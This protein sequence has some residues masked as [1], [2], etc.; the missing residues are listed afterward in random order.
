MDYNALP[1]IPDEPAQAYA[2]F[3]SNESG[4]ELLKAA[5]MD[6]D[7]GAVSHYFEKLTAAGFARGAVDVLAWR[8]SDD[9]RKDV[10]KS[11][12][13]DSP[14]FG[15][16]VLKIA[17]KN[18]QLLAEY[19]NVS[20][21]FALNRMTEEK[22]FGVIA[23]LANDGVVA[24][25]ASL[26]LLVEA[27]KFA[28]VEK[29]AAK[30]PTDVAEALAAPPAVRSA[31]TAEAMEYVIKAR[32]AEFPLT[33]LDVLNCIANG[34]IEGARMLVQDY[35][36]ELP[37]N[38]L[39]ND[40]NKYLTSQTFEGANTL[41]NRVFLKDEV[42]PN[43]AGWLTTGLAGVQDAPMLNTWLD[44]AKPGFQ[45][46]P[47]SGDR[48]G[49][50]NHLRALASK[51]NG[52]E[53]LTVLRDRLGL[54]HGSVEA[55]FGS[56]KT[57]NGGWESAFTP[58]KADL[59]QIA[60]FGAQDA[61]PGYGLN[62]WAAAL[63]QTASD[64]AIEAFAA[65]GIE[66]DRKGFNLAKA[67][68]ASRSRHP[69]QETTDTHH[70]TE[71][72]AALKCYEKFSDRTND[73]FTASE[74]FL[75]LGVTVGQL[76]ADG[77]ECEPVRKAYRENLRPTIG[78][79]PLLEKLAKGELPGGTEA[80]RGWASKF[81]APSQL[82]LDIGGCN[83][84]GKPFAHIALALAPN[85]LCDNEQNL[86]NKYSDMP[87][88]VLAPIFNVQDKDGN[89]V[90]HLLA[91]ETGHKMDYL[92]EM[93]AL[94]ADVL[95][96]NKCGQTPAD[97]AQI[98]YDESRLP[99]VADYSAGAALIAVQAAQTK[100]QKDRGYEGE[101]VPKITGLSSTGA[102]FQAQYELRREGKPALDVTR[103]VTD[104][105]NMKAETL[106]KYP[107]HKLVGAY[108]CTPLKLSDSI[109]P[110]D[111]RAKQ[112]A[113]AEKVANKMV[114]GFDKDRRQRLGRDIAKLEAELARR[115]MYANRMAA[116]APG[117]TSR[118]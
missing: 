62:E 94:G 43:V 16:Q 63:K 106:G 75:G 104:I 10:W 98:R 60:V 25:P 74:V 29:F 77:P 13:E 56:A 107:D 35:G 14:S 11:P 65:V 67:G 20:W 66:I 76:A 42:L 116:I 89:T 23:S 4:R 115:E 45:G 19:G 108:R 37:K 47:S 70:L 80:H 51:D 82:G 93:A 91:K 58:S 30:S 15:V 12:D 32:G 31:F 44:A 53:L 71:K 105:A 26:A 41:E 9:G 34:N 109:T 2:T 111:A 61:F 46:I 38:E 78:G 68:L 113:H 24:T 54:T 1:T 118:A 100:A 88:L 73:G 59:A 48:S 3:R 72:V 21:E 36:V 17:R 102:T 85:T 27:G 22:V 55:Q 92:A 112:V 57:E 40:P 83:S 28:V 101:I 5:F 84:D 64:K 50:N 6:A 49:F 96:R 52:V 110:V 103:V 90:L 114:Q 81:V 86:E 95:A 99:G 79:V 39:T 97:I 117:D 7:I 33:K 8:L 18:P 69:G 87:A